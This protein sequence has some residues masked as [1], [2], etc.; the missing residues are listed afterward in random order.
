MRSS[1]ERKQKR[2]ERKRLKSLQHFEVVEEAS[3][4][5]TEKTDE[6][7]RR[8]PGRVGSPGRQWVRE[9]RRRT[10]DQV[11]HYWRESEGRTE[12]HDLDQSSCGEQW[13]WEPEGRGLREKIGAGNWRRWADRS[14]SCLAAREAKNLGS[15]WQRSSIMRTRDKYQPNWCSW[16]WPRRQRTD[17]T[18]E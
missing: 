15:G 9:A 4:K 18:G 10:R 6:W 5:G 1:K 2:I 3:A 13:G 8:K 12:A 7:D 14:A 16:N 17:S 11:L